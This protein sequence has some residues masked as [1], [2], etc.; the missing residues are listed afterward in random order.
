MSSPKVSSLLTGLD[1]DTL[2]LSLAAR[3]AWGDWLY[4][5]PWD[6]VITLTFNYSASP[7]M[8]TRWFGR[9][10]R[11][12]EQRAQRGLRWFYAVERGAAGLLH[13]HVL[14]RG[15]SEIG[16]AALKAA[17]APGRADAD[18]YDSTRGAA[19][20]ATKHVGRTVEHYDFDFRS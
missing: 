8:A 5:Y 7:D 16:T 12:L 3:S 10:L 4:E 20:Y 19:F 18:R 17:W 14:I 15:T 9:W 2:K 1:A 13:I 6:H 11:R